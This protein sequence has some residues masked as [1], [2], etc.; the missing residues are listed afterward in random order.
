MERSPVRGRILCV[1]HVRLGKGSHY[2]AEATRLLKRRG[3]PCDVR[4]VGAYDPAVVSRPE[5]SGPTY[6]GQVPRDRVRQEFALADVFALP[7]LAEGSPMAHVEALACGVPVIATPNCGSQVRDGCEGFIVPI[8]DADA[9]ADRLEQVVSDRAL[10][11]RMSQAA[12][13]RAR[14][15]SWENFGP[16]LMAVT[17][18]ALARASQRRAS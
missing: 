2:L 1:G 9:L 18:A 13:E 14:E 7:S 3:V 5:F 17:R 4:V 8:R 16:R 11:E 12:T 10:R 6:V 15:L